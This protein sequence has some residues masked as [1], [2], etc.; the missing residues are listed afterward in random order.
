MATGDPPSP[1]VPCR[2]PVQPSTFSS[3]TENH[4]ECRGPRCNGA[5]IHRDLFS[6]LVT[7]SATTS[8]RSCPVAR[9]LIVRKISC[10]GA[11]NLHFRSHSGLTMPRG[12]DD[13]AE[14][15]GPVRPTPSEHFSGVRLFGPG[16]RKKGSNSMPGAGAWTLCSSGEQSRERA[17]KSRGTGPTRLLRNHRRNV[18][19]MRTRGQRSP[20]SQVFLHPWMRSFFRSCCRVSFIARGENDFLHLRRTVN[21]CFR[22][23]NV[24]LRTCSLFRGPSFACCRCSG[25]F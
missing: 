15:W 16:T 12:E 4:P 23:S 20:S 21:D 3:L 24:L 2:S 25:D 8:R 9:A 18:A 7:R 14:G 11:Y 17:F 19:L 22:L 13:G 10:R 6:F 5:S 1:T